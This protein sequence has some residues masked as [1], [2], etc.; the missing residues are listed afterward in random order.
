[1]KTTD[2]PRTDA[3]VSALGHFVPSD[4]ARELERENVLLTNRCNALSCVVI[5]ATDDI[6]KQLAE[7]ANLR[8]WGRIWSDK[9]E[10]LECEIYALENN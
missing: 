9:C 2:T 1:M 5:T 4:F 8:A 3:K 6:N 7:I 10:E